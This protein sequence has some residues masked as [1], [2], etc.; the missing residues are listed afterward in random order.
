[1][2]L[3]KDLSVCDQRAKEKSTEISNARQFFQ[4][5][6]KEGKLYSKCMVENCHRMLSGVQ[7]FNLE[8]H[9]TQ[10]HNIELVDT[11]QSASTTC[12]LCFAKKSRNINIFSTEM[13]VVNTIRTHFP[14]D[15]VS[16]IDLLPKFVCSQCWNQLSKFHDFYVAVNGARITYLASTVKIEDA[17]MSEVNIDYFG[18]A[19]DIPDDEPMVKVEYNDGA[20]EAL[21]NYDNFNDPIGDADVN[22]DVED[23]NGDNIAEYEPDIEEADELQLPIDAKNTGAKIPENSAETVGRKIRLYFNT[24]LPVANS[25]RSQEASSEMASLQKSNHSNDGLIVTSLPAGARRDMTG[26]RMHFHRV[27]KNGKVYSKCLVE[28]CNRILAGEQKFNLER[29][30]KMRHQM[31]PPFNQ[32]KATETACS[33][34]RKNSFFKI[35][36]IGRKLF[37]QCLIENCHRLFLS[38]RK[39]NLERHL[40]VRHKIHQTITLP[41]LFEKESEKSNAQTASQQENGG[42]ENQI[43]HSL[44]SV[45]TPSTVDSNGILFKL[46]ERDGELKSNC[47]VDNRNRLFSSESS[48]LLETHLRVE[49]PFSVQS[50]CTSASQN[51]AQTSNARKYFKCSSEDGKLRSICLFKDCNRKLSGNNKWNLERHLLTMHGTNMDLSDDPMDDTSQG[52]QNSESRSNDVYIYY[53]SDRLNG[54]IFEGITRDGTLYYKCT[55]ENCH[56]ILPGEEHLLRRHLNV[57]H[58]AE[59]A[60]QPNARDYFE[61]VTENGHLFSKCLIE[62]CGRMIAGDQKFNMQ[63]HLRQI[64]KKF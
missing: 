45:S 12:R 35:V 14:S 24:S 2:D 47:A 27:A 19:T 54:C 21:A 37:A 5:V 51:I 15:A 1:M 33:K 39:F 22:H 18:I 23:F 43:N 8:R 11:S 6:L 64:H 50:I 52:D 16:E 42:D 28:N 40:K 44:H 4:R 30:L 48:N 10:V 53:D 63:R 32:R 17:N 56:R 34:R 60:E 59:K 58:K 31:N 46:V 9:L 26:C 41:N 61:R 3:L 49:Q 36:K 29:H 55:M 38:K 25:S 7:K 62:N 57:I 13:D 20:E